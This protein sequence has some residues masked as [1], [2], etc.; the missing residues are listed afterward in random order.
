M[1][2]LFIFIVW[3]VKLTTLILK[4]SGK[5][6]GTALPGLV[7]EKYYPKIIPYILTK[8]SITILITG[9]NG[10]TTTRTIL[11]NILQQ[12]GKVVQN[13]SGSNLIRGIISELIN[14]TDYLGRLDAKYAIFEVEEATIP[15]LSNMLSPQQI[16]VT[17]LFRDQLDAYGEIDRTQKFIQAAIKNCPD[18]TLIL[19][20]DDPRVRQL[21]LAMPNTTYYY[22]I[23]KQYKNLFAYEGEKTDISLKNSSIAKDL[24]IKEDLTSEF[25]LD[26]RKIMLQLPGYYNVYNALAAILSAQLLG[27]SDSKIMNAVQNTLPA[28]GRGEL[29]KYQDKHLQILLVKNPVGFNLNLDLL[30]TLPHTNIVFALNDKIADGRDVSWIWDSNVELIQA[31]KPAQIICSGLRAADM[32]L[33]VKYALPGLKSDKKH[34]YFDKDTG[35]QVKLIPDFR[36]LLTFIQNSK[37]SHFYILSTYT[38]MLEL[39]KLLTGN[40]LNV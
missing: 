23:A 26:D 11:A 36:E 14:Q 27:I 17:N 2:I 7:V 15:R 37:T 28:F 6:R 34:S 39:R 20:G 16:I 12:D 31:I 25:M 22:Q 13:R 33:R 40:S 29:I 9:T 32:L 19:N 24:V 3:A 38:A 1:Q 35:L 8:P 21:N 4:V 30:R 10:K 5:G 18:S